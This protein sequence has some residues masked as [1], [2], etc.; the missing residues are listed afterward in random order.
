MLVEMPARLRI[1]VS[2]IPDK[3]E[4]EPKAAT[5]AARLRRAGIATD[6]GFR[7]NAKRRIET[8]HKRGAE[9]LLF[10]RPA[11]SAGGDLYLRYSGSDIEGLR[12]ISE[13]VQAALDLAS[14]SS[15]TA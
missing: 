3:P 6:F 11:G 13:R 2:V 9:T 1:Q 8:A 4:L 14:L 12:E 5:L 15:G 7:G 10:V